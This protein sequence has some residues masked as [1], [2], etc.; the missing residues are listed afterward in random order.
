M[1]STSSRRYI[2]GQ[3]GGERPVRIGD[4]LLLTASVALLLTASIMVHLTAPVGAQTT[5]PTPTAASSTVP[6]TQ[7]PQQG[8]PP[9]HEAENSDE[10]ADR[11]GSWN[12]E[13]CLVHWVPHG[14]ERDHGVTI[15]P[16]P[17][18]CRDGDHPDYG[19]RE[20]Y[21]EWLAMVQAIGRACRILDYCIYPEADTS[22]RRPGYVS[23]GRSTVGDTSDYGNGGTS[24]P[25]PV[26]P[27]TQKAIDQA[28]KNANRCSVPGRSVEEVNRCIAR[29]GRPV[30][31]TTAPR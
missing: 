25:D 24:S 16:F 5:D 28:I 21:E 26:D 20:C 9:A 3:G 22:G 23:G 1:R 10:C 4:G 13:R 27:N 29:G 15:P 7:P 17:A 30:P 18:K 11:G 19:G 31:A 6:T 12:G 8:R 14:S 2:R